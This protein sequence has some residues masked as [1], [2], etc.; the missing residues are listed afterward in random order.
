M[1]LKE[2]YVIAKCCRPTTGD[3]IAGYY[4]HDNII[5]VHRQ[6]CPNLSTIDSNRV[7]TLDWNE[8]IAAEAPAPGDDYSALDDI[9]FMVMHH[10][11]TMGVDYSLKVASILH[12][13][14]QAV[15]DSHAKLRGMGLLQRVEP[16][17]IQYRKNIVKGT[18]IKHRNH[19]YYELTQ[20]GRDYFAYYMDNR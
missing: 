16:R 7:L 2:D 19:T 3:S 9:D 12:L 5:K 14:K 13:G 17:M 11:K 10:H 18:W 20:K 15:F 6:D 8:I 1:K 4:S